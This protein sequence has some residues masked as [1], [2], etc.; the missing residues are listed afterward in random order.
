ML[1]KFLMELLD[2][3]NEYSFMINHE[4]KKLKEINKTIKQLIKVNEITENKVDLEPYIKEREQ[5]LKNLAELKQ[6]AKKINKIYKILM[7]S[8]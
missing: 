8:E 6:D 2:I 5:H 1:D 3:M 4:K 7:K